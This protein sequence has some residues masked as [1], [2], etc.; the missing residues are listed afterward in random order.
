MIDRGCHISQPIRDKY[1]ARLPARD[2]DRGA[3]GTY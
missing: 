1:G 3:T 2:H